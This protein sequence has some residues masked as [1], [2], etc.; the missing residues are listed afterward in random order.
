MWHPQFIIPTMNCPQWT[1]FQDNQVKSIALSLIYVSTQQWF[2]IQLCSFSFSNENVF[3]SF[4][5]HATWLTNSTFQCVHTYLH[6]QV[7]LFNLWMWEEIVKYFP[8]VWSKLQL[9]VLLACMHFACT[10]TLMH[11]WLCTHTWR[12]CV[13]VY[14]TFAHQHILRPPFFHFT[15]TLL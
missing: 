4:L 11:M 3:F 6:L 5:V 12:A 14:A 10:S 8:S 2:S 7:L 15:L 9:I 1:S 13:Y